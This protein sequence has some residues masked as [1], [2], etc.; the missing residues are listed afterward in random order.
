VKTGKIFASAGCGKTTALLDRLDSVFK[1]GVASRSVLFTTFTRAGAYEAR[2][3]AIE[4]FGFKEDDFPYFRTLHS[5]C[6]RAIVGP[7]IMSR[8][9]YVFLGKDL[10]CRFGSAGLGEELYERG[11]GDAMLA[12]YNLQRNRLHP[13]DLIPNEHGIMISPE[14]Y[15]HFIETYDNYR[16]Y[17]GLYDY[18]DLLEEILEQGISGEFPGLPIQF[19]F[20]DEAQDLTPLQFEVV[21][22]LY[23]QAQEVWFAGDDDQSIFSYS[24]ADPGIL[25]ALKT[26]EQIIQDK[27][28]RLPVPIAR[29]ANEVASRIRLREYKHI[30]A[31][32]EGKSQPERLKRSL[33]FTK[34][35]VKGEPT[36]LLCRNRMFFGY[37][38][39]Q[40]QKAGLLY[41]FVK[42][43]DEEE[44]DKMD[45]AVIRK[46][47]LTWNQM[48]AE[49][50]EPL[51]ASDLAKCFLYLPNKLMPKT[52][53]KAIVDSKPG[54][55]FSYKQLTKDHGLVAQHGW[56]KSLTEIPYERS[57]YMR[58]L[59]K[60]GKLA[61]EPHI[62]IGTIHSFKGKEDDHVMVLPDMAWQTYQN[63]QDEPDS[64]HRVFFVGVSRSRERLTLLH[65]LTK[66]YYHW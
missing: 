55:K 62:R 20:I 34:E 1:A 19:A 28:Y 51:L 59:E 57:L 21:K 46:A 32:H 65:P 11:K 13:T 9:D 39:D 37:F 38:E 58:T 31:Y 27:S 43:V 14:E 25:I 17:H 49:P 30:Q 3:R 33:D 12:L 61:D 36:T 16:N 2:D 50:E 7:K 66:Y 44:V 23:K 42:A 24:G 45:L 52:K 29:Y 64:E 63:Y 60:Q 5:T 56:E 10:H 47:V 6:Y 22:Q 48:M 53:R 15:R 40:L 41:S 18:T 54:T 35:L 8:K 4:K 26:D